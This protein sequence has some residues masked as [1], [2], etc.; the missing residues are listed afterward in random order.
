MQLRH[1]GDSHWFLRHAS[2]LILDATAS[3]FESAPDYN[4]AKGCGFLTAG[5]SR[6]ARDLM[7][8]LV[9]AS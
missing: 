8:R 1:E 3:Q 5:P 4:A 7:A 6:R 2:G 9:W